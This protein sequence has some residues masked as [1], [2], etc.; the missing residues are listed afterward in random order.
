MKYRLI[1]GLSAVLFMTTALAF[2]ES[3]EAELPIVHADTIEKELEECIESSLS[4]V[5]KQFMA[6][7]G[8][9]HCLSEENEPFALAVGDYVFPS[10]SG[11]YNRSQTLWNILRPFA[12]KI[13]LHQ[14][15]ATRYGFDPYNGKANWL[16]PDFRCNDEF[17]HWAGIGKSPIFGFEFAEQWLSIIDIGKE[18]LA[19]LKDFYDCNY[20]APYLP[21]GTRRVYITFEKNAH[22]HLYRLVHTNECLDSVVVLYFPLPDLIYTPLPEWKT[23]PSSVE[24]YSKLASI[25]RSRLNFEQLEQ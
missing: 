10:C 8:T 22:V 18:T 5:F 6:K 14:P 23:Y 15:H 2:I 25:L 9:I 24:A 16:D 17:F 20:Y 1:Y 3:Q 12:D 19:L 21:E 11:G 7:G 4:T 13:C